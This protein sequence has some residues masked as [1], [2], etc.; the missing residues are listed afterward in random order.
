MDR[1]PVHEAVSPL[2]RPVRLLDQLSASC[3]ERHCS[4]CTERAYVSWA[5]RFILANGKLARENKGL[6]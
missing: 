3:R 1:H 5:W 4:L 2:S 6:S